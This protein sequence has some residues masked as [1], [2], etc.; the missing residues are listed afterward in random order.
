MIEITNRDGRTIYLAH[1]AIA[2]I[3]E[4]GTSSQWHGIRSYIKTFDGKI[5]EAQQSAR[6]IK[7]RMQVQEKING[8]G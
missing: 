5:I 8:E 3:T 4:A 7:A 6:E 1:S 2:Q